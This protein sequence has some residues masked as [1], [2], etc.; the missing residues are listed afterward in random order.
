MDMFKIYHKA[1]TLLLRDL[2]RNHSETHSDG[3]LILTKDGARRFLRSTNIEYTESELDEFFELAKFNNS[4]YDKDTIGE[5]EFFEN[6]HAFYADDSKLEASLIR[7]LCISI[8][9]KRNT[10]MALRRFNERV[11]EL[12]D[13]ASKTDT[14]LF[15]DAEQSFIQKA[16]D[17][18]TRQLQTMY[19]KHQPAFILNGYQCYLKAAPYNIRREVER[20]RALDIAVGIKLIRGAY[21]EEERKLAKENLYES[22]VWDTIEDTHISYDAN[23]AHILSNMDP[24]RDYCLLGTH[25]YNS[26]EK[27][28]KIIDRRGLTKQNVGFGQLKGFS[29]SLTFS[30]ADQGYMALK[31]LP[32]GPTE[33]LIPYLIRRGHESKQV[34]REHLFLDDISKEI[35]KRVKF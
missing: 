32:Y 14:K 28:K 25:N 30:L 29:D 13:K 2:F 19:H 11:L 34:M 4:K 1:Q 7:K 27:A 22:P 8:G 12:V 24:D 20:C 3:K 21:M 17:S 9:F 15:I 33:F 23:A 18:Y 5:I 35:W 26:C 31:Y 16:L 6:V 10:R